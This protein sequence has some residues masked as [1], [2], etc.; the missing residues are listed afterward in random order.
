[1]HFTKKKNEHFRRWNLYIMDIHRP[2]SLQVQRAT[3]LFSKLY[4]NPM[5][6]AQENSVE[7]LSSLFALCPSLV[8]SQPNL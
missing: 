5:F 7:I 3:P 1:M 2:T 6:D 4:T 8:A